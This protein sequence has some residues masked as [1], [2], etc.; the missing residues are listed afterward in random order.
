MRD[1]DVDW[2]VYHLITGNPGCTGET[3]LELTGFTMDTVNAS[4]TRLKRYC[5]V[6]FC[7]NSWHTCSLEEIIIRKQMAT[8]LSDGFELSGGI[9]RYR[10]EKEENK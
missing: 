10:P 2:T 5:L 4:L 1:E 8:L 6:E 7:D 3:L 9:I